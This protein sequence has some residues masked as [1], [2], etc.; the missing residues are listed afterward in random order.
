MSENDAQPKASPFAGADDQA[1]SRAEDF[2]T[3]YSNNISIAFSSWEMSLIFGEITGVREDGKPV[4]EEIAKVIM[5]REFAKVLSVLLSRNIASYEERFGEIRSPHF[6][7]LN[8]P[9]VNFDGL[10][11]TPSASPSVSSSASLS[12]S[13]SA[14]PSHPND[15]ESE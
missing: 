6:E 8:E 10:S 1:R 3:F 15:E 12:P 11:R 9:T 2:Y 7:I 13:T 4:I 14:S 5:T